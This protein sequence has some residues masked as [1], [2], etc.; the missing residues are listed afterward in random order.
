MVI[1]LP[2]LVLAIVYGYKLQPPLS[3][4]LRKE[5]EKSQLSTDS[6][7]VDGRDMGLI[8]LSKLQFIAKQEKTFSVNEKGIL[9]DS[10]EFIIKEPGNLKIFY[11]EGSFGRVRKFENLPINIKDNG[12]FTAK[13]YKNPDDENDKTKYVKIP[14]HILYSIIRNSKSVTIDSL[15]AQIKTEK[16]P[17]QRKK[18]L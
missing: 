15:K 7:L 17:S 10:V 14:Y 18:G 4:K 5:L 9:K 8:T 3:G 16:K 12:N 2:A 11:A 1:L 13:I 6:L